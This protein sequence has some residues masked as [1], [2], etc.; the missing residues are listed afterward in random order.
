[1]GRWW[2]LAKL[3]ATTQIQTQTPCQF[4]ICYNMPPKKKRPQIAHRR[5]KQCK[6]CNNIICAFFNQSLV[7]EMVSTQTSLV[8]DMKEGHI[9]DAT[10][11]TIVNLSNSAPVGVPKIKNVCN[12][13]EIVNIS[14]PVIRCRIYLIFCQT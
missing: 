2:G 12:Y 1:M 13:S 5:K 11:T 14:D 6:W 7:M 3:R 8:S 9:S 4:F 10:L